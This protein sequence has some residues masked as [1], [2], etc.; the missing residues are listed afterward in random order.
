MFVG[1]TQL[2]AKLFRAIVATLIL[3]TKYLSLNATLC[4]IS[5]IAY[6]QVP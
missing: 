4:P 6:E 3:A 5:Q 2:G 1:Y